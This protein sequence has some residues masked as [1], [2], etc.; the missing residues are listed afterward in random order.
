MGS[1]T[2]N[3]LTHSHIEVS[4]GHWILEHKLTLHITV[5]EGHEKTNLLTVFI[6]QAHFNHFE[7]LLLLSWSVFLYNRSLSLIP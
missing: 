5:L 6:Q 2:T 7:G 4:K 1:Y 3:E